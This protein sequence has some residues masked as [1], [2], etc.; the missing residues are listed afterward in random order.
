MPP[1]LFYGLTICV[2]PYLVAMVIR[3]MA[4]AGRNRSISSLL[5]HVDQACYVTDADGRFLYFNAACKTWLGE[6]TES[7][8]GRSV[9][10]VED[11]LDTDPIAVALTPPG[12]VTAG[13]GITT[14]VTWAAGPPP[15][16]IAFQAIGKQAPI[17]VAI[18]DVPTPSAATIDAIDYQALR[19]KVLRHRAQTPKLE[20]WPALLGDDERIKHARRQLSVAASTHEHVALIAA[21]GSGAEALAHSL[22]AHHVPT[23]HSASANALANSPL[24]IIDSPLMDAELFDLSASP[25]IAQLTETHEG[26]ATL[27]LKHVDELPIDAA[28][29][30]Q[31]WLHQFPGRLRCISTSLVPLSTLTQRL[32]LG[33]ALQLSTF[34]I[35]IPRLAQRAADIPLLLSA[36]LARRQALGSHAD[37]FARA[38]ID[39]LTM[40]PWPGDYLE[41]EEAVRQAARAC[42]RGAIQADHLPL[43]IRTWRPS[44]PQVVQHQREIHLERFLHAIESELIRRALEQS[45]GQRTEAARRLGI[46]RATLLRRIQELDNLQRQEPSATDV[47]DGAQ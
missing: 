21:R 8:L 33:L 1:V 43:Q 36:T 11:H 23:S 3:N 5:D 44:D 47:G 41:L 15:V 25:A 20:Q 7:L 46:S 45:H 28:E 14:L 29:R 40:Y 2:G 22:H 4:R 10:I 6:H 38:V 18:V 17:I 16:H 27:L 13:Q 35:E 31:Q 34:Q 12:S 37:G 24:A 39:H 30:L 9:R 26:R 42:P 32:P 19:S